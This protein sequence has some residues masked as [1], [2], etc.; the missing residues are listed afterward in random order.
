VP[1]ADRDELLAIL[2]HSVRLVARRRGRAAG[3]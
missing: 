3:A 1:Q 2:D